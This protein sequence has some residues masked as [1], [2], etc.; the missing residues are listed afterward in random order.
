MK[1]NLRKQWNDACLSIGIPALTTDTSAR[2]MAVLLVHGNNEDFTHNMHFVADAEYIQQ[3][4]GLYGTGIPDLE[5]AELLRKYT[6][7]LEEYNDLHKN[8]VEGCIFS[9]AKPEW[10]IRLFKEMYNI[11]I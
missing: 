8:E 10:A 7:E 2:I 1:E 3:K 4:Y 9:D 6:T 5:F 11:K